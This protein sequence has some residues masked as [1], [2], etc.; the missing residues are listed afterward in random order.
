MKKAKKLS[1]KATKKQTQRK[2]PQNRAV[3]SKT[4]RAHIAEGTRLFALAGRPTKAQFV[5]VYG[6]QGPKMTWE[7]RAKAGVDAKH[8]QAALAAKGGG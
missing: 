2:G 1:K 8:F 4:A 3:R 6:P 7:Q 5:K